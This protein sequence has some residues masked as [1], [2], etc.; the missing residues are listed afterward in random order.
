MKK[1]GSAKPT[2]ASRYLDVKTFT[3]FIPTPPK[4]KSGFREREFDKIM[5]G[6]LSEG[7]RAGKLIEE[8]RTA[9][10][11]FRR[12]VEIR[13]RHR[14]VAGFDVDAAVQRD[15]RAA[16]D[17]AKLADILSSQQNISG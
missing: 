13:V 5:H 14:A 15:R 8:H 1:S 12:T 3:Y 16:V 9:V 2:K 10:S 11:L 7:D 17:H 4:R 6:I